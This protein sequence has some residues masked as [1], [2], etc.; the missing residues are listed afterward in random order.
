MAFTGV[1]TGG[2]VQLF[3]RDR[4][5]GTTTLASSDAAGAPADGDVESD[6]AGN[7]L[8]ALSGDG[9][10]AV[11]SSTAT[12]LSPGP[13]STSIARIRSQAR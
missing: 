13:A 10:Y 12:N 6:S 7:V 11:F 5:T 2:K 1:A 9:R 8:F 3:V 4:T